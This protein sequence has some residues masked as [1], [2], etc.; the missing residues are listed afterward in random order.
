[1]SIAG[2]MYLRIKDIHGNELREGDKVQVHEYY[3]RE[4]QIVEEL[5]GEYWNEDGSPGKDHMMGYEL[6]TKDELRGELLMM[7][8][9]I[10]KYDE[11]AY[12]V[13]VTNVM[14]SA[15]QQTPYEIGSGPYLH[16]DIADK[17]THPLFY[18][19]IIERQA[20]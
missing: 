6:C 20:L 13:E 18:F 15:P 11:G 9:G 19:E 5:G 4:Q 8:E 1:M 16:D 10:I 12:F 14:T 2:L 3:N 7:Y 17:Y